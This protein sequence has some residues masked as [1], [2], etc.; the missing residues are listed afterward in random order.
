MQGVNLISS[1]LRL[2]GVLASGETASGAEAADGLDILNDMIDSW[3]T[4]RLMV[5]TIQRQVFSLTSGVQDYTM[6]TGGDFNV[7]RPARIERAGIIS[8]TNPSQPLELPIDYL[9]D[10]QWQNI[11]VKNIQSALSTKV[12]DDQNFP[13][14][15]LHYWPIPNTA[16]DATLYTWTAL[17]QFADLVTDYTFPPGY[18]K[19]L[20]YNLALDLAPEYGREV[21]ASVAAQAVLSKAAIQSLNHPTLDLRCDPA[22]VSP[23][24]RTYNWLSD[25]YGRGNG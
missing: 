19:A 9:T 4:E 15:G 11:P 1:S 13:L 14:R 5:F 23:D 7:D 20:R 10:A 6:G 17:T 16:I 3:N 22:V 18:A 25:T 24:K 21:P 2:I 8:L 12:W